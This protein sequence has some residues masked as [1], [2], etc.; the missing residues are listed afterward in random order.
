MTRFAAPV[1]DPPIDV[2]LIVNTFQKRRHL[3]L[4]LASIAAQRH[5][6]GRFEV[7]VTDDGSTDGTAELVAEF[8]ARASFPVRFV[9]QP[10]DGFRLA[11]IRNNGV[12][13]AAGGYLLFLD[14]DCILP[15]DHLAAYLARRRPGVA[16]I[17]G[18]GRLSEAASAGLDPAD[19]EATDAAQLL[20]RDERRLLARRHRKAWWYDLIRHPS[21]PRLVGNNFG[22]W[23]SDFERVNGCDER[24][25]GWGQEDDDLGLRLRASGVRLESILDRTCSLHVWH[26]T[27]PTATPRWR[28]GP[29]VDYFLRRGRLTACRRGLVDRPA[30]A[31]LW[32]LPADIA[33]TPTG[34]HVL[35][36]LAGARLARPGIP[37]EIE[38][39]IRPG[40]GRFDRPAECRLAVETAGVRAEPALRRRADRIERIDAGD[41]AALES[42]LGAAG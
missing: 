32:G 26:P 27:D 11:R 38:L 39:V 20:P 1:D 22:V 10:H 12:R 35:R 19:L 30:A 3:A 31:V 9:T 14:G 25:R 13:Q 8:A 33:D 21:K 6:D 40:S 7:V 29:N 42:I 5:V 18:C 2:S 15:H 17:G 36:L 24:F 4:V 37:C 23:R 34:R 16:H 28:D 41:D